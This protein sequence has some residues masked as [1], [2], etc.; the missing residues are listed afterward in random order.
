MDKK[1]LGGGGGMKD[2]GWG[3]KKQLT[4]GQISCSAN[5]EGKLSREA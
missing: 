2:K 1:R 4:E 3:R 5:P